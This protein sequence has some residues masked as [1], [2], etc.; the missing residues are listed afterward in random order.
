MASSKAHLFPKDLY[1]Q[2][3]WDRQFSHPARRII[4]RYLHDHGR[5]SFRSIRKLIPLAT[6]TVSQ[7]F[8]YLKR[9]KVICSE[10][11]FPTTYYT[12][13]KRCRK[14]V[15]AKLKHYELIFPPDPTENVSM[16][17]NP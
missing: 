5:S 2:A 1:E 15:A 9:D 3:F 10:D 8:Y 4:L 17:K 12:I 7:H 6:P 11:E 13:R 14:I 16:V